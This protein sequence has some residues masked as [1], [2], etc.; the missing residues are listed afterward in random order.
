M[1]RAGGMQR[2][3]GPASFLKSFNNSPDSEIFACE[4]GKENFFLVTENLQTFFMK[5][6]FQHGMISGV[7]M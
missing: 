1:Q 7:M 4:P 5:K 6:K 3:D 2:P